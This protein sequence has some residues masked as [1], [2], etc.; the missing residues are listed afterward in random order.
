MD[1]DRR[2]YLDILRKQSA[3]YGLRVLGYCLMPNHVHLVAV[4]PAAESLAKAVGRTNFVYTQYINRLHKRSGHLWQNRFF[5]CALD[6]AYLWMALAYVDRNPVRAGLVRR[7]WQYPWSSA[8]A[9]VGQ[10]G[11]SGLLDAKAWRQ[12]SQ[13]IHFRSMLLE[14][15]E[16]GVGRLRSS[17]HTGRPLGSDGFLNKL[18]QALGRRLRPLPVGRPRG[19]R[20]KGRNAARTK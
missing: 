4:P 16:K 13:G 9:H 12:M 18:E 2:V 14:A 17:T 3:K 15:D 20:R 19:T 6:E 5:S 1:D 11:P 10:G 7:A 8:V